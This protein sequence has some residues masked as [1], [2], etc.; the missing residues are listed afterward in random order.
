MNRIIT[1]G[2]C[3]AT[4]LLG[5][6]TYK[7]PIEKESAA[8][9]TSLVYPPVVVVREVAPP[10]VEIVSD[11]FVQPAAAPRSSIPLSRS[12]LQRRVQVVEVEANRELDRLVRILGLSEE[13][14]DQVF[15]ALAQSSPLYTNSMQIQSGTANPI[16]V[17]GEASSA[18]LRED[19]IFEIL[20]PEQ[21]DAYAEDVLEQAS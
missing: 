14:Q 11:P 5:Y 3:A 17:S 13:Q 12:E 10:A 19:A 18:I 6:T 20:D 15:A 8:A 7:A 2:A 4:A 1:S 16:G 9:E 21:Q